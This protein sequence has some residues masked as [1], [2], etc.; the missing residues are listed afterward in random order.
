MLNKI[1]NRF[2]KV[3]RFFLLTLIRL[4]E[5]IGNLL[6]ETEFGC[7]CRG[8]LIRP[9]LGACGRNFQIAIGAK[10]EFKENIY[11]GDN[12]Y[13]GHG[14]WVSGLRGGV[15]LDDE[16]M[17]G[18]Y[19]K[20]VSS[21]HTKVD[22]SYRFG[23][24]IGERIKLGKGSWIAAGVIITAGAEIGEGSLVA[25]G[26]VV[27]KSSPAHAVLQGIPAKVKVLK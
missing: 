19:V 17:L 12:V 25:A 23:P 16:V 4:L 2:M 7:K 3:M 10:L 13:I 21:N 5:V 1:I 9:F 26:A 27:T 20:M 18:P 22:G 6:P 8:A 11:I 14:A 15:E 24:G